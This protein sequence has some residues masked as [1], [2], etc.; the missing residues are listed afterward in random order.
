MRVIRI[1][2]V[3]NSQPYLAIQMFSNVPSS[4]G[5]LS[6]VFWPMTKAVYRRFSRNCALVLE[7]EWS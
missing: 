6:I 4:T 2:E 3:F 5:Q 1:E 7:A